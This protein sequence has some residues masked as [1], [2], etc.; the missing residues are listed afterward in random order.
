MLRPGGE[1][2]I[3]HKDLGVIYV[4]DAVELPWVEEHQQPV[5]QMLM[6]RDFYLKNEKRVWDSSLLF[7]ALQPCAQEASLA[8]CM[9]P[10]W[11]CIC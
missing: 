9:Q 10:A 6:P 2:R 7:M 3:R 5:Q 11:H 4:L 8:G 1:H